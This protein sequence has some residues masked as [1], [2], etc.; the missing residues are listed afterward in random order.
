MEPDAF[1]SEELQRDDIAVVPYSKTRAAKVSSL[2]LLAIALVLS[3]FLVWQM[4]GPGLAFIGFYK[5]MKLGSLSFLT[6]LVVSSAFLWTLAL[7]AVAGIA[8]EFLV[9]D[10][11]VTLIINAIHVF[12]VLA[13]TDAFYKGFVETIKAIGKAGS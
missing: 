10:R 2:V 8:K 6:M 13:A 11:K 7:L 5:D 4:Y 3:V 12:I 9:R 1:A